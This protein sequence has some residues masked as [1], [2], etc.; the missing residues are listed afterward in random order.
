MTASIELHFHFAPHHTV[1]AKT[2]IKMAGGYIQLNVAPELNTA[3]VLVESL[4]H[5][6]R[7]PKYITDSHVWLSTVAADY[8]IEGSE[9]LSGKESDRMAGPLAEI[10]TLYP[11]NTKLPLE[12]TDSMGQSPS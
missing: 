6:E 9:K 5:S 12:L 1:A 11:P 4:R 7:N 8:R 2:K 10:R 3:I